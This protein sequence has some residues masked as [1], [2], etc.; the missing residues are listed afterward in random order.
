MAYGYL[1][2]G[3]RKVATSPEQIRDLARL[4]K[5]GTAYVTDIAD[6][7]RGWSV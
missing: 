1:V 7:R 3:G 6:E 5:D 2:A 4:V